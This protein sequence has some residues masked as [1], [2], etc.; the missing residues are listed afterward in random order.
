MKKIA[1]I[2]LSLT[3]IVIGAIANC[4]ANISSSL[5]TIYVKNTYKEWEE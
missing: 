4:L 2:S 5:E 3:S 1:L